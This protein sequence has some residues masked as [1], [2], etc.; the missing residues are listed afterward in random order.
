MTAYLSLW[1]ES[2]GYRRTLHTLDIGTRMYLRYL[3]Y[4]GAVVVGLQLL[5]VGFV[6]VLP[7]Q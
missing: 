6:L 2:R 1:L 3:I 5:H 7:R 4:G